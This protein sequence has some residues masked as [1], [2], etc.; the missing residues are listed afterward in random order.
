MAKKKVTRSKAQL[1]PAVSRLWGDAK[2]MRRDTEVLLKRERSE[3]VR[4]S[5]E[6]RRLRSDLDK[7]VERTSKDLEACRQDVQNVA[8]RVHRLDQLVRQQMP[9]AATAAP[10]P[11]PSPAAKSLFTFLGRPS[12]AF[13]QPVFAGL[14]RQSRDAAGRSTTHPR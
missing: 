8:R 14:S 6:V 10:P 2:K 11:A 13:A 5:A 3:A 12:L 4:L 7:H 1:N 9:A